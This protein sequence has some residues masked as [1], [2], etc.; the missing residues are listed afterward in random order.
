M[1]FNDKMNDIKKNVD[2]N[3]IEIYNHNNG[4]KKSNFSFFKVISFS[5]NNRLSHFKYFTKAVMMIQ[6]V[7]NNAKIGDVLKY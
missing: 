6:S 3:I 2:R 4:D 7:F 1:V 5:I